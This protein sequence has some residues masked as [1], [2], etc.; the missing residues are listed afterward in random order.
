MIHIP[1]LRRGVPYRSLDIV[2]VPHYQ[3]REPF[4]ELSQAN[5]GLIR[6]DL[7][8]QSE[9]RAQLQR[10]TTRE[11]LEICHKAANLFATA[12]LPL[13]DAQQS[14]EEYLLQV[15][16]T[17][18]LPITLARRNLAKI[19]GVLAQM[20][21]VLHGLTRHLNPEIL[22]R[23]FGEIQGTA[24]SFCPRTESLGVVLPS[25]SPGVHSLWVP[26]IALKIPLV[27][28]PGSAEPW[29]PYRLAQALI[30]AGCPPAAFSYYPTAHAG[31]AEILRQ[32][33]RGMV[34]G[35]TASTRPWKSDSRVEI[36]GPGY[37][38]VVLGEDCAEH[39]EQYLDV[40]VSSILENGGR[41]CVNASGIWVPKHGKQI[42]EAL[43]HRLA[44]IVPRDANDERAQLAPFADHRFAQRISAEIDEGLAI[45]G[46]RDVT[47][48]YRAGE[49]LIQW[50]GCCYL[51]PTI[52]NCD[53]PE[54]P[55]ANREFLF[56]F[57]SVVEVSQDQIPEILGKSLVVT[58]IT[59][60]PGLIKRLI[61]CP[62]VDRLNLGPIPTPQI[63]WDQPH[64]GNLFDHLFFR[65][66]FQ[67]PIE[68]A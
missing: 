57:A 48:P 59:N 12:T 54:H 8:H 55:L 51:A 43:A 21:K 64:E 38:K 58:A 19:Q 11:L 34:F 22:D 13:G 41:S 44:Q 28:K 29:T 6:R 16:A 65:R 15:S 5:L 26:A 60:D 36:H 46:A 45:P 61:D 67:N 56:P 39:W 53:T 33:G 7:L 14:P 42:A 52:V 62:D 10:Y 30:R 31:G 18:G 1:I 40:M 27:L 66:A 4:V 37:S 63:A 24:L 23:G 17:T 47:A 49:R 2:R 68:A 25:N 9:N 20:E 3:K 32:C 50:Q 35:D